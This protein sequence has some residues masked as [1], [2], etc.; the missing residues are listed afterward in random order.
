MMLAMNRAGDDAHYGSL[1]GIG[2]DGAQRWESTVIEEAYAHR[3]LAKHP[4]GE[5][6]TIGDPIDPDVDDNNWLRSC[7]VAL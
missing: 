1:V 4:E 7:L 6:R 2:A 3:V 5:I